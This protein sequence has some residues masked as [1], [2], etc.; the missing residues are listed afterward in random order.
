MTTNLTC[1]ATAAP[2]SEYARPRLAPVFGTEHGTS[3]P[4]TGMPTYGMA[5]LV[6]VL[7]AAVDADPR[8]RIAKQ[9][10]PPRGDLR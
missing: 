6:S 7:D 3:L 4:L 1:I 8:F 5:G 9:G 10:A 2:F